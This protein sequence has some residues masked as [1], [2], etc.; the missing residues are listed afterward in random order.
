MKKLLVLLLSLLMLTA[1]GG[2]SGE[3]AENTKKQCGY[4]HSAK[5]QRRKT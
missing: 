1:C 3:T 2:N 5:F 4:K